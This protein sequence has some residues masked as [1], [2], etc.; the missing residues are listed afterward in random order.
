[1]RFELSLAWRH[2]RAGGSQTVLI[3]FGVAVACTLVIFISGLIFGVQ[4]RIVTDI[5]G[6]LPHIVVKA[7]DQTPRVPN[8]L[9]GV[10]DNALIA[11]DIKNRP[12]QKTELDQWR[13]LEE[14]IVRFPHVVEVSPGVS[15]QA[16]AW[17]AGKE[18]S[19]RV[20][21]AIPER[22]DRI[23]HISDDVVE[24]EFL[25]LQTGEVVMGFKLAANLRVALGDRLRLSSGDGNTMVLRVAGIVNT[26]QDSVDDNWVFMTLRSAQTF[27]QTGTAVTSFSIT[28]NDL[29]AAQP[30]ANELE[31]A[32]GVKAES[33]MEQNGRTLNG[34]RAQSATSIMISVF[35]L[36]AAGFA[37]SSV[38]IVSVLKRSREIGILKSMGA[39]RQQILLIFTLEGL[40]IAI[41]GSTLGALIGTGLILGLRQ[42][43]QPVRIPGRTPDSLL[44]GIV[45]PELV[46]ITLLAAILITVVASVLPARKA[47]L[48]DP[49]EVIRRG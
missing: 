7:P 17:H 37:I 22:Q 25:N 34:L 31:M 36:L 32:L 12:V 28:L 27:F 35:S 14:E 1:M 44:P 16:I 49:V 11:T 13:T 47:A 43:P 19:V 23:V 33:W 3:V 5:T 39:R 20:L 2:L 48:L 41:I 4:R 38:L 45:T 21:G 8:T 10:A 6:S 26:G 9:A 42:I 30:V 24:G 40:G 15:G 46:A 29:F 18:V